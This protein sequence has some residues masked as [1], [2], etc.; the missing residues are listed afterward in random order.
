VTA[1]A[2]SPDPQPAIPSRQGVARTLLAG[3]LSKYALLAASIG[4]GIFLMPFTVRH[5]GK[6][7][8]GLWMLVA[9]LTSYFS[10]LDLGY[11]SGLVRHIV[12][13]DTRGDVRRVN[14]IASTFVCIYAVIGV[15]ACI[16]TSGLMMFVVPHFPHLTDA[17]IRTARIVLALMGIRIA[18]GFPMTVFGAITNARHGF[19]LNN[20]IA[21]VMV[22][23]NAVVT[24]GVLA[25]GGGL[26]TLVA[27]TTAAAMTGYIAY[28]WSAHHVFPG[29]SLRIA[30]FSRAHWR[31]VT[32]FSVYMFVIGMAAQVTFNL[33]NV[34]V[35]AVLGT[36][37]VAVYTVAVRLSEYQRHLCDQFSGMLYTVAVGFGTE[38]RIDR[39]RNVLIEGTRLAV[40]LVVGVTICL[41]GFS[42]PLITRWMGPGFSGSVAPFVVLAI[43][44]VLMVG[45]A[46]QQSILLATGHHRRVTAIWIGEAAANLVLS[47]ILVRRF[48]ALGVA[49]GTAIPIAIGHL[50]VMTPAAARSVGLPLRR[51]A[52]ETVGPALIGGIPAM[53]VCVVMRLTLP[54]PTLGA[55]AL[56]ASVVGGIYIAIIIRFGLDRE[57]RRLYVSQLRG[58]ILTMP[59]VFGRRA[60]SLHASAT[61]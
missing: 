22:I 45:H 57:T 32:S 42:G 35:G 5:L 1:L 17:D 14:E 29:L 6:P 16:V 13:A 59:D 7:Q 19:V 37:A 53:A 44:G 31:E 12:A 4:T 27:A 50:M 43:V 36:S 15:A 11:G 51:Y 54:M 3:T 33:D 28:A 56:A 52:R 41:V 34:I 58:A 26:V 46:T 8:Y 24:Y 21:L 23:L 2:T 40:V 39:L 20:S 18:V 47:L 48:G 55:I 25:S 61:E 49:A 60:P 30:H 9:S 10:L 38:G